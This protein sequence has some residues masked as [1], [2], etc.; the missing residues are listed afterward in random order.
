METCTGTVKFFNELKGWGFITP[1]GSGDEL[2]VH[3]SQIEGTGYRNLHE[4]DRVQYQV[5][6]NGR[7]PQAVKVSVRP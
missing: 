4:G 1:D 2:F 6:D 5:V 7:G 3:Y